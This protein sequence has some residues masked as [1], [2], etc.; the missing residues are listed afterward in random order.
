MTPVP[1]LPLVPH[2]C[3]E[4]FDDALRALA[5]CSDA[6]FACGSVTA[7]VYAA[8]AAGALRHALIALANEGR[9]RSRE[10][11][12]TFDVLRFGEGELVGVGGRW[13]TLRGCAIPGDGRATV[14]A[15]WPMDDVGEGVWLRMDNAVP[16]LAVRG[17][18]VDDGDGSPVFRDEPA[19]D[20]P[21]APS[22][23]HD[24]GR[25]LMRSA[26]FDASRTPAFSVALELALAAGSWLHVASGT[27]WFVDAVGAR[28]IVRMLGSPITIAD[29]GRRRLGGLV[30]QE[31]LLLIERL[32]WR[33]VPTPT[34]A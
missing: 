16:G 33:Q 4:L 3:A 12:S 5:L 8:G 25:D 13:D 27:R 17:R 21:A 28:T 9:L 11:P 23:V 24:L 32:G 22:V 10:D 6:A 30:D 1:R 34:M 2:D 29:E 18:V 31:A 20:R 15:L 14:H 7:R 19:A 26:F